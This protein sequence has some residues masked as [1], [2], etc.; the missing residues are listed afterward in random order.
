M[1]SIL[2]RRGCPPITMNLDFLVLRVSLLAC[3]H[4]QMRLRS[5]LILDWNS[6]IDL[7]AYDSTVSSAY[8]YSYVTV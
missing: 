2:L 8:I 4:S 6:E 3:I 5:E 1:E 7:E